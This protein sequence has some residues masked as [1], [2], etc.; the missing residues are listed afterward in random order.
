M[1][2]RVWAALLLLISVFAMHGLRCAVADAGTHP[3]ATSDAIVAGTELAAVGSADLGRAF[4]MLAA[5]IPAAHPDDVPA[6]TAESS[7]G[8]TGHSTVPNDMGGR[9]WTACLAVLAAVVAVLL[10][11]LAPR[12][13]GLTVP[14]LRRGTVRASG[15]LSPPRP[16]DLSALC[17]LRI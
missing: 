4:T 2:T 9:L 6:A 1:A 15:W 3:T 12:V 17:L 7:G 5:P 13:V 16:P 8:A 14:L 11:V 10:A